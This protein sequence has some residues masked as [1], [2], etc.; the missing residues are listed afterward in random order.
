VSGSPIPLIDTSLYSLPSVITRARDAVL[1][2]FDQWKGSLNAAVVAATTGANSAADARTKHATVAASLATADAQAGTLSLGGTVNNLNQVA[3]KPSSSLT[4]PF[5]GISINLPTSTYEGDWLTNFA[6]QQ[7]VL[8]NQE[9]HNHMVDWSDIPLNENLTGVDL[10]IT[11]P[12][13]LSNLG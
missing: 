3:S 2:A 9:L 1:L 12:N 6:Y 5:E 4:Q 13:S 7:G 8:T 11:I 10:S